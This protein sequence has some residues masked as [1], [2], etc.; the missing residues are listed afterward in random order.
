MDKSVG[1][2]VEAPDSWETAD[3]DKQL[4]LLTLNSKEKSKAKHPLKADHGHRTVEF[5]PPCNPSPPDTSK[6]DLSIITADLDEMLID[7][8][9]NPRERITSALI[10]VLSFLALGSITLFLLSSF[11]TLGS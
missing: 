2:A 7:A 1:A 3:V 8:L 5:D 9:R 10:P 11:S 6:K 4:E